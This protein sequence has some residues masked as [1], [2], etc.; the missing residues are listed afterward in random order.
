MAAFLELGTG[1]K[2]PI[3]GLGTWQCAAMD[4]HLEIY[5]DVYNQQM[6]KFLLWQKLPGSSS[7]PGL[8]PGDPVLLEDPKV[9]EI[10]AKHHKTVAQVLI[11]F[12]IQ[13]NVA[14]IP[15][16]DKRQRLEE[17]FK[18][19]DF[20]LSKEEMDTLLGLNRNWRDCVMADCVNHKDYPFKAEY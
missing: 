9:Q 15:K 8:K 17:N 12:H 16:S 14:V 1:A 4:T 20:E 2:M 19:F 10:A 7:Q 18:V 13:R 11:R 6:D 5:I 3:F